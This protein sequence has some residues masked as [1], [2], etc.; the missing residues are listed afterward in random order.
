M[1]KLIA[2]VGFVGISHI[3]HAVSPVTESIQEETSRRKL[4]ADEAGIMTAVGS[5]CGA[6]VLS[7]AGAYAVKKGCDRKPEYDAELPPPQAA[8]KSQQ[9]A[10]NSPRADAELQ[11]DLESPQAE[12]TGDL[13]ITSPSWNKRSISSSSSAIS[14]V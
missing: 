13:T 7:G 10:A 1:L 5:A 8:A 11:Y 4:L 12:F 9:A 14:S 6:L 3:H 2:T